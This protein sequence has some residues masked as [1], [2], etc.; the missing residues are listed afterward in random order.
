M[1]NDQLRAEFE[2]FIET[3]A[4]EAGLNEP[5]LER[6][7]EYPEAYSDSHVQAAWNGFLNGAMRV[8]EEITPEA[9]T[10]FRESR[11]K[12]ISDCCCKPA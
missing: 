8:V 9:N 2:S 10:S 3:S 12:S 11:R 5:S 6:N 1:D 7:S 4:E